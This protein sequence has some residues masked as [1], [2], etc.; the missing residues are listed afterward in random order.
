[1]GYNITEVSGNGV[2]TGPSTTDPD[3]IFTADLSDPS[4]TTITGQFQADSFFGPT[5]ATFAVDSIS[6]GAFG[7][8]TLDATSGVFTFIIDRSAVI[9]SGTDQ[10]I[11]FNITGTSVLPIVGV[12]SDT[13]IVTLNILICVT[14][15]TLVG[16][17]T[18]LV[19]VEDL[20][21]S[22]LV[23]TLD[24]RAEPI[25]WIG[26]RRVTG[27]ELA[28]DPTLRP[29]R[30]AAGAFGPGRPARDLSVSPQH[31]IHLSGWRAELLF[32]EET[33][34]APAKGLVDDHAVR[35]EHEIED[36]EYFHL[37]FDRHEIILTE[38]LPTE[39]FYPGSHSIGELDSA[40]RTELLRVFPELETADAAPAPAGPALRPWEAR[41]LAIRRLS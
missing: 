41:L 7:V 29:V 1:M 17:P 36:V 18:G 5:G 40:A 3:W 14:H 33:V 24:G 39:S 23:L 2:P 11:S 35:I 21:I 28:H 6:T 34:L 25:R 38:G 4:V 19:P 37:L 31:R 16:T 26:S 30:I 9:A 32:G 22:D 8:L 10:V 20:A 12:A 13:D 15:G 27:G